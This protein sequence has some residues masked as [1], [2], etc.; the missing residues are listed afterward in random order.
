M[1]DLKNKLKVARLELGAIE[2]RIKDVVK[3]RLDDSPTLKVA[4][5]A[6]ESSNELTSDN[7]G[8]MHTWVRFDAK[9]CI[10]VKDAL[11]VDALNE[12]LS[13]HCASVDLKQDAL[14]SYIGDVVTVD[15]DDH[16]V[17]DMTSRKQVIGKNKKSLEVIK[18]AVEMYQNKRGEFNWVILVDRHGSP[19]KA[20]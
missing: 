7:H 8:D 2:E 13:D 5:T 3:A 1:S 6:L 16:S 14:L 10:D 19:I 17:Y 12:Y 15:S 20:L 9:T 4:L 18:R 11:E